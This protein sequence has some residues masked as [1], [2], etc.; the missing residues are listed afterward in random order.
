MLPRDDWVRIPRCPTKKLWARTNEDKG[1]MG[2]EGQ[3]QDRLRK[4][5]GRTG[6][7]RSRTSQGQGQD[8]GRM[9]KG[10]RWAGMVKS[11]MPTRPGK[12]RA[13]TPRQK[14]HSTV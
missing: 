13:R 2:K 10:L 8:M 1:R 12:S 5:K 6:K 9:G 11:W 14:W 3:G 4:D 7:D